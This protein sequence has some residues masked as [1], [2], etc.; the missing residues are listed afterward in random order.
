MLPEVLTSWT[1]LV[2]R[3]SSVELRSGNCAGHSIIDKIPSDCFFFLEFLHSLE[4]CF[5]VIVVGR[6]C[7]Q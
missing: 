5:G 3:V 4:L 2:D 7:L 1:D 6:N